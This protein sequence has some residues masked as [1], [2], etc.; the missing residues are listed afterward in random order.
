MVRRRAEPLGRPYALD[1]IRSVP[2]SE[3]TALGLY[4]FCIIR[5]FCSRRGVHRAVA[6]LSSD[7]HPPAGTASPVRRKPFCNQRPRTACPLA[8]SDRSARC[9]CA[10]GHERKHA[11]GTRHDLAAV[12]VRSFGS[13]PTPASSLRRLRSPW[14]GSSTLRCTQAGKGCARHDERREALLSPAKCRSCRRA[15]PSGCSR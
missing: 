7:V 15:A 9:T 4:L 13:S 6:Q 8:V 5:A 2:K 14:M 1:R 3:L 12:A 11:S 10:G